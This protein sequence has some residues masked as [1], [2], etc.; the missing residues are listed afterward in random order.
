MYS[1]NTL[2]VVQETAD[3]FG[4]VCLALLF[5]SAQVL[6]RNIMFSA[7]NLVS[8]SSQTLDSTRPKSISANNAARLNPIDASLCQAR[9]LVQSQFR[10][11]ERA[12]RG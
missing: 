6:S 9:N 3:T 8:G 2:L 1:L 10:R 11:I 7:F 5:L 4:L 12:L